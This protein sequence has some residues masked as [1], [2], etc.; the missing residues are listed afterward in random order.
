MSPR[1]WSCRRIVVVV[2]ASGQRRTV[3][4]RSL[5]IIVIHRVVSS[6]GFVVDALCRCHPPLSKSCHV[7]VVCWWGG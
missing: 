3:V 2:V 6:P 1:Q 7:I 5:L 4:M